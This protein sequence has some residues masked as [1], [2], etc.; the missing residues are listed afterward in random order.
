MAEVIKVMITNGIVPKSYGGHKK[1]SVEDAGEG[2]RIFER[3]ALVVES[4]MRKIGKVPFTRFPC[5]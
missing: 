5:E 1:C 4:A 2:K 3:N